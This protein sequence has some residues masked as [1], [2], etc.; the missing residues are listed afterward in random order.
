M[1]NAIKKYIYIG[2]CFL[3]INSMLLIMLS[4]KMG[5]GLLII[6]VC[7][8][9]S[10]VRTIFMVS[11]ECKTSVISSSN[12]HSNVSSFLLEILTIT[13]AKRLRNRDMRGK[14]MYSQDRWMLPLGLQQLSIH[15]Q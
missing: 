3:L 14:Q 10:N 8:I 12:N 13:E 9:L 1:L 15:R 4:I 6:A 11:N 2:Y 5:G 7:F